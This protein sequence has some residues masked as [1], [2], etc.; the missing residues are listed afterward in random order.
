MGVR[1]LFF[2][3]GMGEYLG[4]TN[5]G[6]G[7]QTLAKSF[8]IQGDELW[9]KNKKIYQ[10]ERDK[11]WQGPQG[12]ILVL[13]GP[14][15]G[16]VIDRA[17]L[18]PDIDKEPVGSRPDTVGPAEVCSSLLMQ[19]CI[20]WPGGLFFPPP[21]FKVPIFFPQIFGLHTHTHPLGVKKMPP[22]PLN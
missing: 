11:L 15:Q 10:K 6:K 19:G 17:P 22:P 3:G 20:F 12:Q 2:P 21:A 18:P 1:K 4:R 16:G 13:C 14:G 7:G 8:V 9:Q 5:F